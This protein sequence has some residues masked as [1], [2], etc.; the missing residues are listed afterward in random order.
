VVKCADCGG[1]GRFGRH[2]CKRCKGLGLVSCPTCGGRK[3]VHCPIC[4][5]A[6]KKRGYL[7]CPRCKGTGRRGKVKKSD[8]ERKQ[9]EVRKLAAA[10]SRQ[11]LTI[12]E[13][14]TAEWPYAILHRAKTA[15]ISLP[16]RIEAPASTRAVLAA[17]SVGDS[18]S[19]AYSAIDNANPA[20]GL[21][22]VNSEPPTDR[23]LQ[24]ALLASAAEQASRYILSAVRDARISQLK[25]QATA[26]SQAG[27]SDAAVEAL[28]GAAL[29]M[30]RHKP[31]EA[32]KILKTLR[33][34]DKADR[35]QAPAGDQ[36]GIAAPA[37]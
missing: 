19:R 35:A 15:S 31:H 13:E 17:R 14:F 26:F 18:V 2:M 27:E 4:S 20:V 32:R 9:A 24:A 8:I 23:D 6:K 37:R 11:P 12:I 16:I 29:L 1:T 22:P 34:L 30:E 10:L 25:A 36:A 5:T 3:T 33:S 28:L 7:V 21:R